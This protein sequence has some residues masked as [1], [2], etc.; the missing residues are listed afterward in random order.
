MNKERIVRQLLPVLLLLIAAVLLCGCIRIVKKEP[1]ET[2]EQGNGGPAETEV[3]ET[4]APETEAP[5]T[6][7]T[8]PPEKPA[9]P[10]AP[11]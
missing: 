10:E 11:R 8:E 9:P 4:D 6:D 2:G 1:P 7:E 3:P 5:E